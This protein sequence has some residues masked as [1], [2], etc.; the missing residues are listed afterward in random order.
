ML[1]DIYI[2][3]LL[4][5][6][7]N[8]LCMIIGYYIG[9]ASVWSEINSNGGITKEDGED[10][11][12]DEIYE[13]PEW[14]MTNG[15]NEIILTDGKSRLKMTPYGMFIDKGTGEWEF[16]ECSDLGYDLERGDVYEAA[17]RDR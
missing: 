9:R 14:D 4:W 16:I 3:I 17:E 11:D 5:L 7:V 8:G 10:L 15:H 13:K 1:I 6:L 2:G 12:L